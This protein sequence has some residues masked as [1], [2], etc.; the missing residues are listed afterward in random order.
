M[1]ASCD[2]VLGGLAVAHHAE[3][4]REDRPLVAAH[5]FA[6]GELAPLLGEANDVGIGKCGQLVGVRHSVRWRRPG[7]AWDQT[8]H[9]ECA[10]IWRV[11]AACEC[12]HRL[13]RRCVGECSRCV[14][15][16]CRSSP[17]APERA[18]H[19]RQRSSGRGRC[20]TARASA[21]TCSRCSPRSRRATTCSITCCRST[22]TRPGGE[23]ALARAATGRE[24][25]AGDYLDLCAGTL[26]VGAAL[27]A[28]AG[29]R[30]PRHRSGLR[31]AD[32]SARC[33][34]GA[35]RASR[36]GG[37]R[38]AGAAA[39][40]RRA[41]R[42]DRRVRHSQRGRPRRRASRSASRAQARRALRHPRVLHTTRRVIVRARYHAYFH[43]VLPVDR[44]PRERTRFGVHAICRC[45]SHTFPTEG[46]S[47]TSCARGI[48]TRDVASD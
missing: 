31:G 36:A 42:R 48:L 1:N 47:P 12:A 3:D 18:S 25:P 23:R 6:E 15:L 37:R 16:A 27:V 30:R 28:R 5:E 34:Q 46:D 44:A 45:R 26:D 21:S 32:A 22:S 38:C 39:C 41:R 14:S 9:R 33:W 35:A 29:F 19:D 2:E 7:C 24:R 17:D 11:H 20:R 40:R 13:L 4:E 43:H 10:R 8:H